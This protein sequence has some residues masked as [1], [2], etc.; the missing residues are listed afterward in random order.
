M[1]S[2]KQKTSAKE[3]LE[4]ELK[5]IGKPGLA[6]KI[7]GM[8]VG[9][10]SLLDLKPH[11]FPES[12]KFVAKAYEMVEEEYQSACALENA[13]Q[14]AEYEHTTHRDDEVLDGV[15]AYAV[16]YASAI[17]VTA[18]C[19]GMGDRLPRKN[20]KYI[21]GKGDMRWSFPKGELEELKTCK[22]I[23]FFLNEDGSRYV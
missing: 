8:V 17:E 12:F 9:A 4:V 10:R 6:G 15:D 14:A 20:R 7:Y 2:T 22:A 1:I 16:I 23:S 3:Y 11:F 19:T 21:G 18:N 13:I 5:R